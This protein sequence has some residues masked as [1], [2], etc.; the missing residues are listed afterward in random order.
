[1]RWADFVAWVNQSKPDVMIDLYNW[2]TLIAGGLAL[3]GAL[4]TVWHI[5]RQ[6]RQADV[7][8]KQRLHREEDAAKAVL[9]LA[10]S[11]II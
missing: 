9:P 5:R 2:Q 8:A 3:F 1:M 7:L 11:A 6:I 10:L 4:V